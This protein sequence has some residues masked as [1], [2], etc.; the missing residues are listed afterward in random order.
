MEQRT[1][2]FDT[3]LQSQLL[4]DFKQKSKIKSQEH[5]KFVA[6]KQCNETSKT[7]IN[8]GETYDVDCQEENFTKFLKRVRTA[9][10]GSDDGG[11]F[12]GPYK[13]VVAVKPMN[14]YSNNQPH[15]PMVSKKRSRSGTM[16]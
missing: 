4:S 11:L 7:K 15:D 9:C 16:L 10:F 3:N 8:L 6:D 2:V 14:N 12:V 1:Q 5:S 13:Q